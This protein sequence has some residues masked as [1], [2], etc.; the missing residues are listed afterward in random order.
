MS[1]NIVILDISSHS[2]MSLYNVT[3]VTFAA[4]SVTNNLTKQVQTI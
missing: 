2:F 3:S 1:L 4:T